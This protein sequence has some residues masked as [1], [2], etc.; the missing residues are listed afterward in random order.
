MLEEIRSRIA[1]DYRTIPQPDVGVRL[2]DAKALLSEVDRR[3][4]ALMMIAEG[5]SDPAGLAR[6]VLARK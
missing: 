4:V 5:C 6:D 1:G 3:S 2:A